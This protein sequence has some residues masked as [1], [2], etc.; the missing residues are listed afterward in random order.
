MSIQVEVS[1][2]H[3]A[4]ESKQSSEEMTRQKIQTRENSVSVREAVGRGESPVTENRW[5]SES[6]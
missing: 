1:G 3:W 5:A 2:R 6:C 4:K